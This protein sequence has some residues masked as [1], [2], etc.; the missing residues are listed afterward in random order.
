M[1]RRAW[2]RWLLLLILGIYGIATIGFSITDLDDTDDELLFRKGHAYLAGQFDSDHDHPPLSALIGLMFAFDRGYTEVEPYRW[3]HAAL[4]VAGSA[5]VVIVMECLG[6]GV[7]AVLVALLV[8]TTPPLKAMAALNVSDSDI[9]VFLMLAALG[10]YCRIEAEG[11]IRRIATMICAGLF[12]GFAATTKPSGLGYLPFLVVAPLCARRRS[13]SVD[14]VCA[15]T[16]FAFSFWLSYLF[17]ADALRFYADVLAVQRQHFK[18]GYAAI[19]FGQRFDHG[20]WYFYL[21]Q[22][23]MKLALPTLMILTAGWALTLAGRWRSASAEILCFLLPALALLGTFSLASVQP[24]IRYVLP[25]V[26]LAIVGASVAIDRALSSAAPRVQRWAAPAVLM[27]T[28]ILVTTDAHAL[29]S[30]SYL[31]YFNVLATNPTRQFAFST[32]DWS[33]G[34]PHHLRGYYPPT[35]AFADIR[36]A[37]VLTEGKEAPIYVQVG[38]TALS[39][40][41]PDRAQVLAR[42]TPRW[43][44]A[45]YEIHELSP[46]QLFSV[47]GWADLERDV[48]ECP[49][50]GVATALVRDARIVQEVAA[51]AVTRPTLALLPDPDAKAR[52]WLMT[53]GDIKA[54]VADVDSMSP[55]LLIAADCPPAPMRP[56]ASP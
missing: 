24:G 4:Y 14:V 55:I 1:R 52:R 28:A 20:V 18:E 16:A 26:G 53:E 29:W 25:V 38:A 47:L 44:V 43:T 22:L 17:H 23:A 30:G 6:L 5:A 51:A 48:L 2:G 13:W 42:R 56:K 50:Q 10:L 32:I 41:T 19:V 34:I 3:G 12:V 35:V 36:F 27:L 21:V 9:V 45:G 7:A 11:R 8:S 33:Q 37:D 31:A 54:L 40:A 46:L 15:V 49:E 39:G